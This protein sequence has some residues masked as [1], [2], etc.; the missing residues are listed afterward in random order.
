LGGSEFGI[1]GVILLMISIYIIAKQIQNP[2]VCR[3]NP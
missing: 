3:I 2:A 1:L